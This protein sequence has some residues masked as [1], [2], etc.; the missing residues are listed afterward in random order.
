MDFYVGQNGSSRHL[1]EQV[2]ALTAQLMA[3][4]EV[5]ETKKRLIQDLMRQKDRL[6]AQVETIPI[7]E[8][9][10]HCCLSFLC[11]PCPFYVSH[12]LLFIANQSFVNVLPVFMQGDLA[13]GYH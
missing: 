3:A 13:P 8:A 9:Q 10:V 7:H 1:E 2:D 12:Q 11:P 5:M 4:S 6:T